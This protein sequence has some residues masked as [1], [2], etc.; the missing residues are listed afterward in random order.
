MVECPFALFPP[1]VIICF[2]GVFVSQL[3][4]LLLPLDGWL[5][6]VGPWVL[7]LSVEEDFLILEV[8]LLACLAMHKGRFELELTSAFSLS[9]FLLFTDYYSFGSLE[10]H[11]TDVGATI[12]LLWVATIVDTHHSPKMAACDLTFEFAQTLALT[13]E[14]STWPMSSF[15]F[16]L[17]MMTS[18]DV[19]TNL[20]FFYIELYTLGWWGD[21][22][23]TCYC[24]I[25]SD[26][27]LSPRDLNFCQS[28]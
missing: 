12:F 17:E 21:T 14:Y 28:F 13:P 20:L 24:P 4:F 15:F 26:V 16:W 19:L 7:L 8:L 27:F 9:I 22:K 23:L 25:V 5:P 6:E 2:E 10:V 1:L 3:E 11:S 18:L